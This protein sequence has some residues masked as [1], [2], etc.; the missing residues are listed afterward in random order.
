MSACVRPE[1]LTGRKIAYIMFF[2]EAEADQ[3]QDSLK[4]N[5]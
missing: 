3:M 5:I 4:G 2:S 1:K